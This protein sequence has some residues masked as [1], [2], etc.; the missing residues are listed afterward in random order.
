MAETSPPSGPP[1][2]CETP[3]LAELL[4]H[5]LVFR[6]PTGRLRAVPPAAAL[7]RLLLARQRELAEAN[8][9]LADRYAELDRL[10]RDLPRPGWTPGIGEVELVR[11]GDEI[12][13]RLHELVSGTRHD[14]RHV[15]GQQLA[16]GPPGW[17]AQVRGGAA[18]VRVICTPETLA[19]TAVPDRPGT[20][21][22]LPV[23]AIREA[24]TDNNAE[25]AAEASWQPLS[26]NAGVP[27]SPNF[28]AYVSGH[29]TFG[30]AW[31]GI[32]RRYFGT[33]NVT[34]TA[35]TEDP[36]AVGVTRTFSTFTAAAVENA[37]SRVYLG[38][39]YQW[40]GDNGVAAGDSVAGHVY[41]SYLR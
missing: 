33:D 15:R 35:T 14:C 20:C 22:L 7:R 37:R 28:P 17:P 36:H 12:V 11:G 6:T 9:E 16:D 34:Y 3:A 5:A 1:E 23:S 29:A 32:M 30:G 24:G 13:G 26:N 19:R 2:A 8:R 25:T 18:R 38:V 41:A 40:D 31:A 27:F 4:R 39:H 21:R 10:E